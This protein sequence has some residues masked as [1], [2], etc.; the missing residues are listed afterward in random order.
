MT[1]TALTSTTAALTTTA[2]RVTP[3]TSLPTTSPLTSGIVNGANASDDTAS[4]SDSGGSKAGPIAGA[5]IGILVIG[6]IAAFFALKYRKKKARAAEDAAIFQY[7]NQPGAGGASVGKGQAAGYNQQID[8]VDDLNNGAGYGYQQ[9]GEKDFGYSEKPVG[10]GMA[11]YGTLGLAAAAAHPHNGPGRDSAYSASSAALLGPDGRPIQPGGFMGSPHNSMQATAFINDYPPTPQQ[12]FPQSARGSFASGAPY[13]ENGYH[14]QQ[15]Q[16]QMFVNTSVPPVQQDRSLVSPLGTAAGV[17][18]PNSPAPTTQ[19][20]QSM[21]SVAAAAAA[22]ALGGAA[23]AAAQQ[24][25]PEQDSPFGDPAYEGKVFLVTRIF[26][27]S[28]PDELVIYPG[29]HIQI[30]MSYDDGWCLGCNLDSTKRDGKPAARGVFPRDCVEEMTETDEDKPISSGNGDLQRAPTLP[31]LDMGNSSRF[32]MS[33]NSAPNSAVQQDKRMSKRLS[34]VQPNESEADDEMDD[35]YGG[36]AATSAT[37]TQSAFPPDIQIQS[38]DPLPPP[39]PLSHSFGSS[40]HI[41][42]YA[43]GLDNKRLSVL[44]EGDENSSGIL[45]EFPSTPRTEASPSMASQASPA[46]SAARLSVAGIPKSTSA[47]SIKRTSSLIASKD[48]E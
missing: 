4:T 14:G 21:N 27:P 26:E 38:H 46:G 42:D 23:G 2:A 16:P 39:R 25:G 11:G 20:R 10:S 18:L 15:Q 24:Q 31:P 34:R 48:A 8:S 7:G 41:A 17:P 3:T 6:A 33:S 36:V 32:S 30:V 45:D 47:R 29:D 1:T 43:S 28:M 22:A 37:P 35:A 40:Q 13:Q 5:V 12:G 9:N 19:T 44:Q